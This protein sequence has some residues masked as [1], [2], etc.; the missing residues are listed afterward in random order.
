M[1]VN[2]GTKLR[3]LNGIK[4]SLAFALLGTKST[5][6]ETLQS[7]WCILKSPWQPLKIQ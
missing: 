2:N 4:F 3:E 7:E 1:Y 6:L 5:D